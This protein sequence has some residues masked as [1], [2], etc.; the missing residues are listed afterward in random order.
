MSHILLSGC[1]LAP[2]PP[3]WLE[4]AAMD[5]FHGEHVLQETMNKWGEQY[6]ERQLNKDG[7]ISINA[8]THAIYLDDPSLEWTKR[9]ITADAKDIRLA[10][11]TPGRPRNGPHI[12]KTRSWTLLYLLRNGGDDAETVHYKEN[13]VDELIRPNS[14]HVDDYDNVTAIS[15]CKIPLRTWYLLNARV[16]HSI[17]NISQG[18]MSLQ[19]SFD[20]FPAELELQDARY[21][22]L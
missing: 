4:Q 2:T 3:Q 14:Y 11:T 10:F 16:L 6:T 15:S 9:N 12:D 18:R 20:D 22:P 8:F 1:V 17:E 7:E 13:G 5:L 21:Y 19:V